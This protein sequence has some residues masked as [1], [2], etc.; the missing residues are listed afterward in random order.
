MG[1]RSSFVRLR[2]FGSE[3]CKRGGIDVTYVVDDIPFN[4]D[5]KNLKLHER[6]RV[7]YTPDATSLKQIPSRR[8]VLLDLNADLIHVL[9]PMPKM[10]MALVGSRAAR[11]T[12]CGLGYVAGAQQA[13]ADR[14]DPRAQPIAGHATTLSCMSSPANISRPSSNGSSTS[15][16]PTCRSRRI[17]KDGARMASR[18]IQQPTAVY[19]GNLYD[20][21]YDHDLVLHA[22]KILRD[23][24]GKTPPLYVIGSGP[25]QEKWARWVSDENLTNVTLTGFLTGDDLWRHVRHGHVLLFPIRP[26]LQNLCRCP[27]KTFAYAQARGR[28]SRTA[29]VKW[30]NCFVTR[31]STLTRRRTHMRMRSSGR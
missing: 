5:L 18:R 31:R 30:K 21:V 26:T 14:I 24:R 16:R 27:S 28:S 22:M 9:N 25:D 19:L 23:E 29:S 13:T 10:W 1:G 3:M 6:A 20:S 8:R 7:M 11:E 15:T 2:E 17:S 4:R 12:R